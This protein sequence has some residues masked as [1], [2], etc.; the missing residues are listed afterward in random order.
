METLKKNYIEKCKLFSNPLFKTL[1]NEYL[2]G[3]V[4]IEKSNKIK[5]F[6][7]NFIETVESDTDLEE[8]EST[9]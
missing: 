5:T 8:P 4:R 2:R 3:K 9:S 1:K 7:Y 6:L